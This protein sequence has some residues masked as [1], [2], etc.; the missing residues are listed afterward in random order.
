MASQT[1]RVHETDST[2]TV[3][4]NLDDMPQLDRYI[5]CLAANVGTRLLAAGSPN[6]NTIGAPA[7]S[8]VLTSDT[9]GRIEVTATFER[10][11]R[12]D[13]YT[14]YLGFDRSAGNATM[15]FAADYA[16]AS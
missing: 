1:V 15:P 2:G 4:F 11:H 7:Y 13:C 5:R 6:M 12:R 9:R 14:C 3:A 16:R 10:H 8:A